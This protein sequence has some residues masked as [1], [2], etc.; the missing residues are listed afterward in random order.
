MIVG[1][2]CLQVKT[3]SGDHVVHSISLCC[4]HLVHSTKLV[5]V[6]T[7]KLCGRHYAQT[8]LVADNDPAQ[9]FACA[10]GVDNDTDGKIDL[11]DPDCSALNDNDE[12]S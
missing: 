11:A 7:P 2:E 6:R 4:H 1:A 10:D 12:S 8:N 3:E 9:S 5:S